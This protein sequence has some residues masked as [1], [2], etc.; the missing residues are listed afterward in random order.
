MCFPPFLAPESVQGVR[1]R[2]TT[3]EK[4]ENKEGGLSKISNRGKK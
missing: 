4:K 3:V 2:A 1:G